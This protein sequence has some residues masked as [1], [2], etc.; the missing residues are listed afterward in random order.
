MLA[1]NASDMF[2]DGYEPPTF[3]CSEQSNAGNGDGLG[4]VSQESGASSSVGFVGY[5]LESLPGGVAQ[6]MYDATIAA[7]T[8][9][10]GIYGTESVPDGSGNSGGGGSGYYDN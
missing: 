2:A 4:G 1:Y 9:G 3:L 5:D 7:G 10:P 6:A 8:S